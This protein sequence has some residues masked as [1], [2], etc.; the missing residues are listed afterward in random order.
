MMFTTNVDSSKNCPTTAV[1]PTATRIATIARMIGSPAATVA[2][3]TSSNTSSASDTPIS[4]PRSSVSSAS[5]LN[6]SLRLSLPT[7]VIRNPSL[8]ASIASITAT[9]TRPSPSTETSAV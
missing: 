4:S 3:N 2:P 9:V 1:A 6:S 5:V 7:V 8:L